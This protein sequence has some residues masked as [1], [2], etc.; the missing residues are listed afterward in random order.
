MKRSREAAASTGHAGSKQDVLH[1]STKASCDR[2]YVLVEPAV[3]GSQ[4]RTGETQNSIIAL[5]VS[6][7]DSK[8][9]QDS[10]MLRKT[11]ATGKAKKPIWN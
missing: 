6:L 2:G 4:H 5:S 9:G 7:L 11:T 3:R 1:A 8:E 10:S